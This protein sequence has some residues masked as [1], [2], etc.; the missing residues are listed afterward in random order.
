VSARLSSTRSDGAD[1]DAELEIHFASGLRATLRVSWVAPEVA[2]DLQA[3]SDTGVL[4]LELLPEL[5]LEHDGEPVALPTRYQ[6][7]DP[8][9][10]QFGYVDQLLDLVAGELKR[11]K[12]AHSNRAIFGGSYG[13]ASAGRFHH[14]NSQVHR[15]LNTIGGYVR[16]ND[17][18]S[19]GA[20]RVLLPHVLMPIDE[21]WNQL[22]SWDVMAAHTKLFV[23]FGG[24]PLNNAQISSANSTSRFRMPVTGHGGNRTGRLG[25]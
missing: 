8:R 16:H 3:A 12:D 4:R 11:V 7:P 2:W 9:L 23:A 20:G 10:E 19:L 18:Y 24:V 22:T 6:V 17:S 21:S 13:L 15:F 5:L 14:A 1:D 25:D